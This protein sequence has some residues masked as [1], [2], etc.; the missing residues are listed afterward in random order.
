MKLNDCLVQ[1]N[2]VTSTIGQ[3][4]IWHLLI[5]ILFAVS[6]QSHLPPDLSEPVTVNEG[7]LS[8]LIKPED[9]GWSGYY[10]VDNARYLP[11]FGPVSPEKV[12]G[13]NASPFSN[14]G[15]AQNFAPDEPQGVGQTVAIF[16][17]ETDA[18]QEFESFTQEPLLE[19]GG[20]QIYDKNIDKR[21]D[22]FFARCHF[23]DISG[24]GQLE[25]C[26]ASIQHGRYYMHLSISI[27]GNVSTKEDWAMFL[28]VIQ[29]RLVE[30]VAQES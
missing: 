18:A 16:E 25:G 7:M 4:R 2:S 24:F 20:W 15:K 19:A 14:S 1:I 13:A 30:K 21:V 26:T 8:L 27:D 28:I 10:A 12:W 3:K 17:T 11:M 22:N 29:D 6:C 5:M 23:Y 9:L